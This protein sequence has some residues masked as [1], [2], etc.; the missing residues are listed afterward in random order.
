MRD[1]LAALERGVLDGVLRHDDDP[2]LR[3]HLAWTVADRADSGSS[4]GS[5]KQTA[6]VQLTR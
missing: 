1:A 5:P 6:H 3:E 4:G 2:V